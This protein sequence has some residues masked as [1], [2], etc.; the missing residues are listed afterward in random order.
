MP[1]QEP[2]A[3]LPR[4]TWKKAGIH[5]RFQ[6]MARPYPSV[7]WFPS[8]D[9]KKRLQPLLGELKAMKDEKAGDE[10]KADARE[11][12]AA[13]SLGGGNPSETIAPPAQTI[14]PVSL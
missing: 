6:R 10:P 1:Y 12:Q 14:T 8:A 3:A 7:R 13:A 4:T 5:S 9:D 11:E 2:R